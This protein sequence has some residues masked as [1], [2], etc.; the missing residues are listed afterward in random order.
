[1]FQRRYLLH[2][3]LLIVALII[4]VYPY[5]KN[6]PAAEKVAASS[7]ASQQF[8]QLLDDQDYQQAWQLGSN[9]LKSEIP[10]E[11]WLE[12]LAY[13]RRET[14]ALQQ[15]TRTDLK[16]TKDQV[17]GVPDGEYMSFFYTA[18]FEG[19]KNVRERVT[20]FLENGLDWRVA[21]YFVE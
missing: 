5:Y 20:L 7:V 17:E 9:Y 8:L 3:S 18:D 15:R 11:K 4:I 1:M 16:Y 19:K 6:Q 12:Q 10:L 2:L 21:G 14:G 13:V